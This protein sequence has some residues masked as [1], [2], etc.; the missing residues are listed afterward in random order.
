MIELALGALDL[1]QAKPLEAYAGLPARKSA[2]AL[3]VPF[4]L[5]FRPYGAPSPASACGESS[6]TMVAQSPRPFATVEE[7]F[8]DAGEVHLGLAGR[9]A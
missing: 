8:E 6:I 4:E 5:R 9:R 1:I 2:A 3:L 7:E